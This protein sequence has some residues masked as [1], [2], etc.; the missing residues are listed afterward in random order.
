MI[1]QDSL[2]QGGLP[3]I[4]AAVTCLAL[5]YLASVR[6][7][8]FVTYW[9]AAW[10]LLMLRYTWNLIAPVHPPFWSAAVSEWFRL[11]FGLAIAGGVLRVRHVRIAPWLE[12]ASATTVLAGLLA[13][14]FLAGAWGASLLTEVVVA[15]SLALSAWLLATHR[16]LPSFERWA[17]ALALIAY[18]G[19]SGAAVQLNTRG[20]LFL[21][22]TAASWGA[23]VMVA[24]AM[25]GVFFRL[26][27]EA[28][29]QR[30]RQVGQSM[31]RVLAGFLPIC[32][33]CKSIRVGDDRWQKLEHYV[34]ERSDV[35][36]S[37]GLCPTCARDHYGMDL[38]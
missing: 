29:L 17:T 21:S 4:F 11:M 10:A 12:A 18:A 6:R 13:S 25:I 7:D 23:E 37:H 24:V 22:M 32:M 14:E 28:E 5:G 27:Y 1:L 35:T 31:A 19:F 33:W 26:A 9:T 38:D 15:V 2:F 16:E 36:F 20:P 30:Q 34:G 3:M 8:L